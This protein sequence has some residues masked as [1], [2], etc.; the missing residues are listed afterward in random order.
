[1]VH[2]KLAPAER[3]P[4]AESSKQEQAADELSTDIIGVREP[5]ADAR[6]ERSDAE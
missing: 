6:E 2:G 3:G 4:S 5:G 1:L